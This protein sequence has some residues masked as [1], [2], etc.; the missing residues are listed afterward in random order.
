MRMASVPAPF[1]DAPM[2]LKKL[3]RS[4]MWG[5]LAALWMQVMPGAETAASMEFTVA[6][7][8]GISKKMSAPISSSAFAESVPPRMSTSTPR[9]RMPLS[10]WSMGRSPR[11]QPPGSGTSARMKFP[12]STGTR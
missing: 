1:T 4:T 12:S 11:S 8:E 2:L 5:S 3:A 7:T 10:V 6:P 9:A